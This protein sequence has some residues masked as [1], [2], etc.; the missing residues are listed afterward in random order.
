MNNQEPKRPA[1]RPPAKDRAKLRGVSLHI[2]V[3]AALKAQIQLDAASLG[4]SVSAYVEEYL[5][6]MIGGKR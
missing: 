5:A 3:T 2:R 6:R 1:G 4:M